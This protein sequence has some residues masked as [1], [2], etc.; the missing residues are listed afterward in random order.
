[1]DELITDIKK[2]QGFYLITFSGGGSLKVPQPVLRA[3]PMKVG[4]QM[5]PD[6]YFSSHHKEVVRFAMER[7]AYLLE[8]K[9]YPVKQLHEKL[10]I[11]GY[12]EE[13]SDEV[14]HY[15]LTRG[16][17]D[18]KR[19]A[20]QFV[21]RKKGKMGVRRI[22]QELLTRGISKTHADEAL[23]V[24]INDEDQTMSAADH[25]RKYIRTRTNVDA[26]KLKNNTIAMLARRG[27]S[28]EV[29]KKAYESALESS[30]NPDN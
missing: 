10:I 9:D 2:V 7:A 22:R 15:L 6:I 20:A 17:L 26:L 8:R 14:T 24:A 12:T 28:F 16:F 18:D 23:A 13:V 4:G 11:A 19:Y 30:E 27:Y 3:F 25:A 21:Q 5:N 29:A 1:M